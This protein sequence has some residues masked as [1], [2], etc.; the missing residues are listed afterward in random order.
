MKVIFM[1][2]PDFAAKTLQ[3]LIDSRHEIAA[4]FTQPDKPKGRGKEISMS[5]VKAL[6]LKHNLTVY[7]PVKI[8]EQEYVD[9]IMKM[10]ADV[11]VVTAFGQLLPNAI[12]EAPRYGCINV[13]ASLLPMYR[14][15]APIQMAVIDGQKEAG[16]TT[17]QMGTGL[18]T[19]DMLLRKAIPVERKETGGS[20]F[21]KLSVEGAKLLIETL[22]RAENGT[23]KPE[24]QDDSKAS[25]AKRLDKTLGRLDFSQDAVVLERLIRGLNPWPSAYGSYN[26]KT[27]KIWDADVLDG[28]FAGENGEITDIG[29]GSF[30]VKCGK[31]ALKI[32]ELQLEGKR[33][34][35]TADFLRGNKI[36]KGENISN[37]RGE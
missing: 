11:I 4:V 28:D 23:L 1:G 21:D 32:N 33:R 8:R 10:N 20:L 17:M 25:Y 34:M 36:L 15:A 13:H 22:E 7:Q 5:P 2:T 18:D 31:G 3:A 12:L 35:K 37:S 30:T 24:K 26:G 29:D 14:G 16:V 6:A 9:L 27:L 19:G